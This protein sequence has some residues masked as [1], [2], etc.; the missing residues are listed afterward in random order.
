MM[1]FRRGMVILLSIVLAAATVLAGCSRNEGTNT[2]NGSSSGEA[3]ENAANNAGAEGGEGTPAGLVD[4]N[5][6]IDVTFTQYINYD[7]VTDAKWGEDEASKWVKENKGVTVEYVSSGGNA[8]QKLTT[9]IATNELPD[10]MVIERGAQLDQLLKSDLLLPLDEYYGKYPN[11]KKWASEKTLNA[12]RSE[13]GKIYGVPNWFT[14]EENPL[15]NSGWI[16]NKKIYQELGSPKLETYDD[17]DQFLDQVKA[18]YPKVIPMHVGSGVGGGGV[19]YA[20]FGEG[21]NEATAGLWVY[22]DGDMLKNIWEDP[23]YVEYLKYLNRN[24][25]EGKIQ[26]DAFTEK[27]EQ[28]GERVNNGLIAVSPVKDIGGTSKSASDAYQKVDP[29]GGYQ[30]IFPP[31]HKAGLDPARLTPS[32]YS[33]VGWNITVIT[34]AA[35]DKA[36]KIFAYLDWLAGDEGNATMAYGPRGYQWDELKD[37]NGTLIPIY[38]EAYKTMSDEQKGK[39]TSWS[40]MWVNNG[41]WAAQVSAYLYTLSPPAPGTWDGEATIQQA[42]K[43][44]MNTDIYQNLSFDPTTDVGVAYNSVKE[45]Y[46]NLFAKAVLAKSEAE[47]DAVV[48]EAKDVAGK[49]NYEKVLAALNEKFQNNLQTIG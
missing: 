47:V 45:Q 39:A 2:N 40:N 25:R 29:Q 28:V 1:G 6:K 19:L 18:K 33:A 5:G 10:T 27:A 38:N 7:W 41:A 46:Q 13:D 42:R 3:S 11:L 12:L 16:V 23:A 14:N 31:I 43:Y 49:L 21:R 34:K 17:L 20:G 22:R 48:Q 32:H 4:Q 26:P 30:P 35:G 24:Y 37:V 8:Q 36:E 44:A 15:G 9:L